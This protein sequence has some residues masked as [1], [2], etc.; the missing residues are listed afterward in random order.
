MFKLVIL[1]EPLGDRLAFDG[2]WPEF[3]HL[4]EAMPNLRREA[5]SQVRQPLL[6]APYLMM[7]ELFFDNYADLENAMNSEPGKQAGRLIQRL[8]GSRM[9]LFI[10]EHSEDSLENIHAHTQQSGEGS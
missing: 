2:M 9:A 8:T 3:L 10:A 1:I 7:H 6:G 4:A 5:T